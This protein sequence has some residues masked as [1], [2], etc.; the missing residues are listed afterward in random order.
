VKPE[1]PNKE[2]HAY[3]TI[4]VLLREGSWLKVDGDHNSE[5][6]VLSQTSKQNQIAEDRN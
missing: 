5:R 1:T 3:N 4:P 6:R 2:F